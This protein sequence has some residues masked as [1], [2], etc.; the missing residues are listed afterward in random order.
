MTL[1]RGEYEMTPKLTFYP[2]G[3]ADC[4][5]IRLADNRLL[6]MD[7]AATRGDEAD[8][9]RIDLPKALREDIGDRNDV[10]VLAI[11]HLDEDHYKRVSEVFFMEHAAKY[12]DSDRI[13]IDELWVP[14][15]V[16]VEKGPDAEEARI[17]QAEARYRMKEGKRIRVFSRPKSL[18]AWLKGQ[19][20]KLSERVHLITDAGCLIPGFSF[21]SGGVEFFVHSPFVQAAA[22]G[23]V[24]MRTSTSLALHA[25]FE[26]NA[27]WTRVFFG[28]DL[29]HEDLTGVVT[30]T[31]K[32]ANEHRLKWDVVKL[33]HH[34]SYLSLGP[35]KGAH[36]T[37]PVPE[38]AWLYESQGQNGAIL[39][40]CSDSMPPDDTSDP[41]HRQ[42]AKYYEQVVKQLRGELVVTMEH[43]KKSAPERLIID[44]GG[45]GSS[46]QKKTIVDDRF[47][48]NSPNF[49]VLM[50]AALTAFA[51]L[52]SALI[53][54]MQFVSS[55]NPAFEIVL[56]NDE[57]VLYQTRGRDYVL[58][59]I[60]LISCG[61]EESNGITN[62]AYFG[63]DNTSVVSGL[64]GKGYFITSKFGTIVRNSCPELKDPRSRYMEVRIGYTISL[65][66]II[67]NKTT[68]RL[69]WRYDSG[70]VQ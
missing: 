8:D 1:Y 48:K 38:V 43:P 45:S 29:D 15:A 39:V 44:I 67:I 5:L 52:M 64:S 34:C 46:L 23:T 54:G 61:G 13:K 58:D 17:I 21:A 51:A 18:E 9:P 32:H 59:S 28:A 3:N 20:L 47:E 56:H 24:I 53:A 55:T 36:V 6:V 4:C 22:D 37:D 33:P 35:E 7:F 68:K 30:A 27:R 60:R 62:A 42:A 10:D 70:G 16:I 41:P 31:K 11:S 14:A 40:S 50:I 12:Q 49:P 66:G 25:T 26:V 65:L 19:G 2:L 69:S 57:I 63:E